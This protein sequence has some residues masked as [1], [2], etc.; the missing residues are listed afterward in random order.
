MPY[1]IL[2]KYS[3]SWTDI[4]P[5]GLNG[6]ANNNSVTTS[7][8]DNTQ[9]SLKGLDFYFVLTYQYSSAPSSSGSIE[10]TLEASRDGTNWTDIGNPVR[11]FFLTS[12]TSVHRIFVNLLSFLPNGIIP[13]SLFRIRITNKGGQSLASSGNSLFY[14][15]ANVEI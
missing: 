9:S 5:S 1:P 7:A 2:S 8:I 15:V 10:F 4:T 11:G 3:S 14:Q 13:P 6:L 12:D